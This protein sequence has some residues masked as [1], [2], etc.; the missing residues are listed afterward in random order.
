MG[1]CFGRGHFGRGH[2][3]CFPSIPGSLIW[4]VSALVRIWKS[5]H[6]ILPSVLTITSHLK[7]KKST[8]MPTQ[9]PRGKE[10]TEIC[11]GSEK[12]DVLITTQRSDLSKIN[13]WSVGLKI[14]YKQLNFPSSSG[15]FNSMFWLCLQSCPSHAWHQPPDFIKNLF[16]LV[17]E[18]IRDASHKANFTCTSAKSCPY[19]NV[20]PRV[21]FIQLLM[22]V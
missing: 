21:A 13:P 2:L 12:R 4:E 20:I 9:Q 14:T 3:C 7:Q 22:D 11:P 15:L 17:W 6:D 16:S 18:C 5:C 1:S 10:C 19:R 8:E